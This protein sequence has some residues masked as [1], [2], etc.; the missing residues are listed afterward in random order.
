MS[1]VRRGLLGLAGGCLVLVL[2]AWGTSR[3]GSSATHAISRLT[4]TPPAGFEPVADIAGMQPPPAVSL[5]TGWLYL[6]DP[7][8]VGL[9][10][11][12]AHGGASRRHWSSVSVPN[13][14]NP[15]VNRA[16]Y[17]GSD[18]WYKVR[19]PAPSASPAR[20]WAVRFGE[21]RRRAD[22][23][24]NGVKIGSST[25]NFAPF[26]L[27]ATGLRPG[28][29]NLL[30]VRVDSRRTAASFPQDW[31]NWGGIT[32]PVQLVPVG[33]VAVED[34]AAMPELGCGYRCADLLV[35]GTIRNLGSVPVRAQFTVDLRAPGGAAWGLSHAGP[36]LA[37]HASVPVSFR[38]PVRGAVRLWAPGHPSL[39]SVQIATRVQN[40]VEQS[41]S[42][43]VGLRS[44]QV[45]RGILYLNGQ[46]L[47]LHGASIHEDVKGRGAALTGHDITTIVSEL[48]S[49]GANIT[50]AHYLLSDRLLQALDAAGI[51][52]WSQPPV[53]HADPVLR[54]ASGRSLALALL[55]TTIIGARSHP[56][57]IINSVGNEL[58]PTPE[59][60]PGTR[61][62]MESAMP[63]ARRLDP[64]AAV[65]VDTYCYPGFPA[66]QVYQGAD[67]IGISDYFGW[68]QGRPGH[69][70]SDFAGL[71]PFLNTTHARYP[72]QALVIAEFGA[73]GLYD[74]PMTSKGSYTFQADYLR[75]TFGVLDQLP[76]MN[77]AIYWTM[78]EFAVNPG[79]VGGADLP[80]DDRPDGLHHK[81][82]ISYAGV[83][84]PAFG[85]AQQLFA[86]TPPYMH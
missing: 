51:L 53:D 38:V 8:N 46:R 72:K 31:W 68:Y 43:R 65:A 63:L 4:S 12:W 56:S 62:Y 69:S 52:V 33:R 48:K 16:G 9:Q 57:V 10:R 5:N 45:R 84:K 15:V 22:V 58:S 78:R 81:G 61:L 11:D 64:A 41:D 47:W 20:T 83:E 85:V 54:T 39:Y 40:R 24:L 79:W 42:M 67:V 76:F 34:L 36:L 82:L 86:Q 21:V 80:P 55:R 3:G 23:W 28:R 73:E 14:F 77:G 60:T 32:Q 49:V 35:Q 26:S 50:R 27:P 1:P 29:A 71:E 66:Q 75:K 70:I 30:V 25:D 18:G 74:G 44:I 37:A 17:G 13:D 59:T 2:V 19:F 7:G 6:P